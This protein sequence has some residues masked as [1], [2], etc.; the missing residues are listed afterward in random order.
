VLG[1]TPSSQRFEVKP[2]GSIRGEIDVPGDKSISHRSLM[3][4]AIADGVT[5]VRGFLAG[6][7][8]LATH[9]ALTALGV[10]ITVDSDSTVHVEGRGLRG[11][12]PA[13]G[14]LDLGNS[15]TAIRLMTGLLAGQEFD[16][17]LTGD[18]S[19]RQRPMARVADPLKAMGARIETTEG[20]APLYVRGGATLHGIDYQ[21]P[22]ASAQVKSALL[23]AAI[24][25]DGRTTLRS[26]GPSRDH[27]ERMLTTMGVAVQTDL[28]QRVV[29]VDGPVRLRACAIDVPGDLSSAAFFVV[30]ACLAGGPGLLIRNV[31]INPT[32]TGVLTILESMGARIE[33]RN[34]RR[35][36]SE[37]VAD[38]YVERSRLRGVAIPPELVPL[39]IDEFPILFIA[40]AGAEGRTVVAGA[41]E[42][43]HKESDRIAVMAGALASV[44]AHVQER[45]DGLA[46]DGGRLHGGRIDSNGDHR[47]AMAFAIASLI[48]DAPIEILNTDQVATSFPTFSNTAAEAGIGIEVHDGGRE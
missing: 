15:G 48:S 39:A 37:P 10:G 1:V 16:S 25:A 21:L 24:G 46:I 36:G 47:V 40:A 23:L 42:L 8:C 4:G 29:S 38:L 31:G 44:G 43:R 45:A 14:A 11:L 32:R 17:L 30:A 35:F 26:P 19:L 28:E 7:D 12:R 5:T 3:L 27:T 2:G 41:E 20:R 9:N 6:E 13:A 34:I 22:V 33:R 18:A